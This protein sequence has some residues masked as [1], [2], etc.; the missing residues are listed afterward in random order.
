M[1]VLTP[2]KLGIAQRSDTTHKI[3][4]EKVGR[5]G[6]PYFWE[7]GILQRQPYLTM[8]KTLIVLPQVM[9]IKALWM[10]HNLPI[11]GH[12]GR[13]RMLKALREQVNWPGIAKDVSLMCASCQVCQKSGPALLSKAPLHPLP[14]ITEPF[15]R[16]AMDVV[17]SKRI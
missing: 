7:K 9:R 8:G 5:E 11:A 12:F 3:I 1:G 4:R 15:K 16:I 13:E 14:I 6:S 10:A 2:Q 17:G